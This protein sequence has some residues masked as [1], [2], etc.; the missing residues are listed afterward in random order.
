MDQRFQ[1][2]ELI[3]RGLVS[4]GRF[5]CWKISPRWTRKKRW[6]KVFCP[7]YCVYRYYVLDCRNNII[8]RCYFNS[9]HYSLNYLIEAQ[10]SNDS[11][12][13]EWWDDNIWSS[14]LVNRLLVTSTFFSHNLFKIDA[15]Q[16]RFVYHISTCGVKKSARR[17]KYTTNCYHTNRLTLHIL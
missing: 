13:K 16:I 1:G 3:F 10:Q 12:W 9:L 11:G 6:E 7:R 14:Y 15:S 17:K 4:S 8:L 5:Q 2:T